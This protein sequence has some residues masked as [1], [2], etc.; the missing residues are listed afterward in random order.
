MDPVELSVAI[1]SKVDCGAVVGMDGG[2]MDLHGSKL[3]AINNYPCI[4]P[5]A[6]I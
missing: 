6:R 1:C 4:P 5:I 2:A 3:Q